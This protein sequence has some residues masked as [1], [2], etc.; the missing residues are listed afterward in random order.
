MSTTI[1]AGVTASISLTAKQVIIGRG[2]GVAVIASTQASFTQAL[3][4]G[5]EWRIGP[6][7]QDRTVGLTAGVSAV[8]YDVS[9]FVDPSRRVVVGDDGTPRDSKNGAAVSG[10]RVLLVSSD[11]TITTA[12]QDTYSDAVL[13]VTGV[14]AITLSAGLKDNVAFSVIPSAG[15]CSIVSDGTVLLNG[16]TTSIARAYAGNPMFVVQQ[17]A[18]NRNSYIVSGV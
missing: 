5:D 13:E 10:A 12:N 4:A 17:R 14:Y 3:T 11:V 6:F 18:S 15:G 1:N 9:T 7:D 2:P 16:A 8:T